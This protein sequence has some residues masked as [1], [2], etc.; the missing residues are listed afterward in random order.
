MNVQ[1]GFA[2]ALRRVYPATVFSYPQCRGWVC[3]ETWCGRSSVTFDSHCLNK[4]VAEGKQFSQPIGNCAGSHVRGHAIVVGVVCRQSF[5]RSGPVAREA[6]FVK[7]MRLAQLVS[8]GVAHRAFGL[9]A[10]GDFRY[11]R[12]VF[13]ETS[14]SLAISRIERPAPFN[15]YISFTCPT[16]SNLSGAPPQKVRR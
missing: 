14:S 5:R 10:S 13:R 3:R 7:A 1:I 12:T 2:D 9:I 8:A 11:R 4:N 15:S 16:F 6:R